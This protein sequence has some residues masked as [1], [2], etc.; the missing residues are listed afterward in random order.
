M[1]EPDREPDTRIVTNKHF[2]I[3]W[4]ANIALFGGVGL[5]I[6][7]ALLSLLSGKG[8]FYIIALITIV[9]AASTM[10][11]A[12]RVPDERARGTAALAIVLNILLFII[13]L[14]FFIFFREAAQTI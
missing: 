6:L 10:N 14:I 3:Q 1:H 8:I 12:K 13:I 9:F 11:L 7:G 2:T 4:M 5:S